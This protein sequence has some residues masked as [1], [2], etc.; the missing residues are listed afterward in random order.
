MEDNVI[1]LYKRDMPELRKE[2]IVSGILPA[3]RASR[4][5]EKSASRGARRQRADGTVP[6]ATWDAVRRPG[7]GFGIHQAVREVPLLWKNGLRLRDR[8]GEIRI[9]PVGCAGGIPLPLHRTRAGVPARIRRG[10]GRSGAV[11]D[12]SKRRRR[13]FTVSGSSERPAR[14]EAPSPGNLKTL[15]SV[16]RCVMPRDILELRKDETTRREAPILA[17]AL[18][19]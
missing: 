8:P 14:G 18:A 4:P 11:R 7:V 6:P 19:T 10:V 12:A 1:P 3:S 2:W 5:S 17:V 9:R 15:Y 16:R 13:R